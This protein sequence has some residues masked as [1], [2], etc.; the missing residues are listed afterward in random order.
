MVGVV[1]VGDLRYCP[2]LKKYEKLIEECGLQY[3]VLFWNRSDIVYDSEKYISYNRHSELK[4]NKLLK[5]KDFYHFRKWLLEKLREKKYNKLI[6][7]STLSGML[8]A[9]K[10]ICS[11]P[12]KYILD[13][14]DYSYERILPFFVEEKRII[15]RS[16]FTTISSRGFC[17]FLPPDYP[18]VLSHN[19]SECTEVP[20]LRFKKKNEKVLNVVWLGTIRYIGQQAELMK[21]L[22]HD[23][24]FR[25]LYYGDGPELDMFK[26]FADRNCLKNVFFY[27]AYNNED[28][29][30]LL[31]EADIINNCYAVNMETKY[32][33]SN[34]F[35]DGIFYHIPQLVEPKTFKAKMA[36]KYGIG[37]ALDPLEDSFS[38]KLYRYYSQIDEDKF[39]NFCD[40]LKKKFLK[41]E[42]H[43]TKMIKNFLNG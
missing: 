9:E 22:S 7:L 3:E 4:K 13:I 29:A 33:V 12:H 42:L 26:D 30:K 28:K 14:R 24:R 5:V 2:Y 11:Y 15:E 36:S 19:I 40:N 21:K 38:E 6:I 10:L 16:A 41:E 32:A 25:I 23:G 39:N 37:V 1:F 17:A 31:E 27:G 18:Y 34:K 20:E 35:Y 8:I 43:N